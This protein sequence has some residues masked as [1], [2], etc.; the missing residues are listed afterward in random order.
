MLLA[1]YSKVLIYEQSCVRFTAASAGPIYFALSQ[2]P[3]VLDTWYYLRI[4]KVFITLTDMFS[5][6]T[7]LKSL[8]MGFY[9]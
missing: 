5:L 7:F 1:K 6:C 4:A 3:S 9:Y 8:S 2:V